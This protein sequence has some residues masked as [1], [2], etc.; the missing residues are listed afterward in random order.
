MVVR[1]SHFAVMRAWEVGVREVVA[2]KEWRSAR[3]ER[4][5]VLWWF[6]SE[7]DM[8]GCFESGEDMVGCFE[9]GEDMIGW[10]YVRDGYCEKWC[11]YLRW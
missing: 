8:V 6:E 2:R 3:R 1:R 9:S 7:E 10:E 11:G 4:A 5:V